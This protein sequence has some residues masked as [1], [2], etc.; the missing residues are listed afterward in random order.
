MKLKFE[1]LFRLY[2]WSL[3]ALLFWAVWASAQPLAVTNA[4]PSTN[5]VAEASKTKSGLLARKLEDLQQK[6]EEHDLIFHLDSVDF[7]REHTLL[8]QPLWKYLSSL[9]YILLAFYF[10]KFLD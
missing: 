9:I 1:R 3:V 2:V 4:V 5:A 10:Y 6:L 7:L 8:R